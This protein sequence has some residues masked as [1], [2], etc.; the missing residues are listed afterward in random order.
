MIARATL[1]DA[2]FARGCDG[3]VGGAAANPLGNKPFNIFFAVENS[4]PEQY[5]WAAG[6]S[7]SFAFQGL[8]RTAPELGELLRRVEFAHGVPRLLMTGWLSLSERA[9]LDDDRSIG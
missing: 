3:R 5:I 7:R 6:P 9:G 4:P 2:G 8:F 1:H